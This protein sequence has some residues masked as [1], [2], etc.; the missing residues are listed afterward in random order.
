MNLPDF[1][2]PI[3]SPLEKG[4]IKRR[5]QLALDLLRGKPVMYRIGIVE[6]NVYYPDTVSTSRVHITDSIFRQLDDIGYP[7]NYKQPH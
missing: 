4:N 7:V 5:V 1:R 6:G 2:Y 3:T